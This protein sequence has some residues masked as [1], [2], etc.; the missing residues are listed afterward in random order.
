MGR[1]AAIQPRK[2]RL[3]VMASLS[4]VTLAADETTAGRLADAIGEVC[5]KRKWTAQQVLT[6]ALLQFCILEGVMGDGSTS[7]QIN[8]ADSAAAWRRTFNRRRAR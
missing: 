6:E 7:G 1:Y 5:H 4:G 2:G 8:G 3:V